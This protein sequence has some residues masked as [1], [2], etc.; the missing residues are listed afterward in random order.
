MESWEEVEEAESLPI[1]YIGVSP[2]FDTPTKTDTKTAWGLEGLA[3]IRAFSKYPLVAIGGINQ[4]NAREVTGA[5]A[6]S[7]A[8]VSA[9]C[10]ADDP[11][12][13][14]EDLRR[15]AF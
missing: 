11:E 3:K 5:G 4:T 7:I 10:S 13:A 12:K 1:D 15:A 8:V 6:H 9:I 2:V 14:V